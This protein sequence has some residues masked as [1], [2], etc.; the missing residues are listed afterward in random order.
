MTR[1]RLTGV[2][3]ALVVGT[4]L[5]A[6]GDDGPGVA[7]L[8][9]VAL[10]TTVQAWSDLSVDVVDA[11]RVA[12]RELDA[13]ERRAR[14]RS[15]FDE[16]LAVQ[17]RLVAALDHLDPPADVRERIDE[18]VAR[19]ATI[20]TDGAAAADALPDSAYDVRGI[21]D[22]SLVTGTEKSKAVVFAAL[23]ALSDDPATGVPRGCGRRGALDI[24]PAVTFPP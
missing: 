6:C 10:C 24:S 22:G 7:P 8:D 21:R 3:T 15:A 14:Y 16:Q 19:V 20:I 1:R 4:S 23:S 12:S 5:V 2:V 17:E 11:F 13:P 18:A 9:A